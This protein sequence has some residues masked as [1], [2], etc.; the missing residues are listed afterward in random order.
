MSRLYRPAIP[1]E[2]RCRVALRQLGESNIDEII[3]NNRAQP[4]NGYMSG[5]GASTAGHKSLGRLLETL[6]PRLADHLNCKE[7]DLRLDHDP[8]LENRMRRTITKIWRGEIK[9]ITIYSP[10]ANDQRSLTYRE[11][12]AHHIKT[13]VRGEHGQFPDNTIAKR[14]RRRQKKEQ[15][16]PCSRCFARYRIPPSRLCGRCQK[17]A[18]KLRDKVKRK[19]PSR[20]FPKRR[21]HDR[22]RSR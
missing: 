4:T 6:L 10:D 15:K 16:T 2:V 13:N 11:K 14:E 8:A 22:P 19:W 17:G 12:H 18:E 21:K 3:E 7:A 20:P 9:Q 5:I 1:V